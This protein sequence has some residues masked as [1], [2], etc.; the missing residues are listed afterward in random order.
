MMRLASVVG[1]AL[2]AA[3]SLSAAGCGGGGK[4]PKI[5]GSVTLDNKP[6]ADA[7]VEFHPRDNVNMISAEAWTDADGKFE[8][9]PRPKASGPGL[10]AGSYVVIV[11][12]WVDKDGK[13]PSPE[14]RG[15]LD[16]AGGAGGVKNVAPAK[17]GD[18]AFP[19]LTIEVKEGATALDPIKLT[20]N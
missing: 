16:A 13:I 17:Y 10:P 6:Y 20:S 14:D 8:I 2:V 19:N 7:K 12:K 3:L 4:A 5:N 9:P 11:K 1:V 18:T 15:M